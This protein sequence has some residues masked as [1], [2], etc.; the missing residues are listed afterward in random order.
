M[1]IST[2]SQALSILTCENISFCCGLITEFQTPISTEEFALDEKASQ[3]RKREFVA[4]RNCLRKAIASIYSEAFII[5][6]SENGKPELPRAIAGSLSHKYPFVAGVAGLSAKYH[7]L[8]IDIETLENWDEKAASVFVNS[9]DK[10]HMRQLGIRFDEFCSISF[11]AKES[12]YKALSN[13]NSDQPLDIHSITPVFEPSSKGIYNFLVQHHE[14]E[15]IGR[16]QLIG[17]W[18]IAVCWIK[19]FV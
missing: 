1:D 18:V 15:C 9:S 11:S 17:R 3:R 7:S 6:R 16:L 5:K 13:I 10:Q 8:G 14:V 19:N 12:S 4:G 2:I